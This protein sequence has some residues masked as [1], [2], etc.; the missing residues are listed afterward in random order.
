M[1][2]VDK[3]PFLMFIIGIAGGTGSGKTTVVRKLIERLPKGEVVV[4]PLDSY[5]NDSSNVPIEDRQKINFDHPDAFEW[6]LLS[7]HLEM[8]KQGK[9]VEQPIYDYITSS[10]L[11]ETVHVE[12]REIII[13]E[14][15]MT[16]HNPALRE[17]MDLKV[18]VD[19]D[20]DDRLI[21][22]IKRDIVE[23]GRT[24]DA[25]IE[26]YQK[27]LKPMH[28]QFIEPCKRYANVIIPQGG[29]NN[30]AINMMAKFIKQQLRD[31]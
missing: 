12:P 24:V 26:R 29:H 22:V 13:V 18:F 14:G 6:P 28:E 2:S 31:Q 30:A 19:A 5:Y 10:R 1:Q 16:L 17:Q 3:H 23:R 8:L 11:K 4:I 20:G 15:I 21:R 27:V 25:V 7:K 9:S